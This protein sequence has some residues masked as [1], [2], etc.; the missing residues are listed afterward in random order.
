MSCIR[1]SSLACWL[2]RLSLRKDLVEG[3]CLMLECYH[4]MGNNASGLGRRR[5]VPL[6]IS[7]C[8]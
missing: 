5:M 4:L 7:M 1:F 2:L 3:P 8:I 6:E